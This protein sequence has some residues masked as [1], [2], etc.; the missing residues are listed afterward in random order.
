MQARSRLYAR[1][2]KG[3]LDLGLEPARIG[4]DGNR[5]WAQ[6]NS[7]GGLLP[8]RPE[9]GIHEVSPDQNYRVGSRRVDGDRVFHYCHAEEILRG[10]RGAFTDGHRYYP[11]NQVEPPLWGNPIT[12]GAAQ[13]ATSLTYESRVPVAE[14]ELA[15]GY[16]ACWSPY[17]CQRIKS[18]TASVGVEP[19]CELTVYFEEPLVQAIAA[20]SEVIGYPN[21]YRHC[22]DY[23]GPTFGQ[24]WA[25]VCCIPYGPGNAVP[26]DQWFWGLTW[27][28][29]ELV[30]NKHGN[31][32]GRHVNMRVVYFGH[33]G[34]IVYQGV[35]GPQLATQQLQHAGR[36]M[37]DSHPHPPAEDNSP[38][39]D[40]FIF[41][42]LAP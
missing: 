30:V 6:I 41:I 37:F 12:P 2:A 9:Q 4:A 42:E 18:N 3:D 24:V 35:L 27:G 36:I 14:N 28:P 19:N 1:R 7:P 39:G 26:A 15:E 20:N 8:G 25:S 17:I 34:G 31:L 32:V 10:F 21:I 16:L 38:Y 40:N 33:D 29:T 22:V 5:R 23:G 13:Y 11:T